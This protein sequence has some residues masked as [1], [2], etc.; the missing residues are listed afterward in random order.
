M[1]FLW[2]FI[3][4]VIIFAISYQK[5]IE[6]RIGLLLQILFDTLESY[7]NTFLM[8]ALVDWQVLLVVIRAMTF[9]IKKMNV[10]FGNELLYL[11]RILKHFI[12]V[13]K[14]LYVLSYIQKAIKLVLSVLQ[15]LSILLHFFL[16]LKIYFYV[17]IV[18]SL[19][20]FRLQSIAIYTYLN[21][22]FHNYEEF[23]S[24]VTLAENGLSRLK[25]LIFNPFKYLDPVSL[26]H[27]T[28][29]V[30]VKTELFE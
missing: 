20:V 11:C 22:T 10:F 18:L 21:R 13:Y 2:A 29:S 24:I 4:I 14:L 30:F 9:S 26:R 19:I 23:I 12:W 8:D 17:D 3:M 25:A 15:N 7:S 28:I 27:V 6:F 5:V 16:L 1:L